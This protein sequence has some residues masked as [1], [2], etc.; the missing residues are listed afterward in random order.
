MNFCLGLNVELHRGYYNHL[1]KMFTSMRRK[2]T[3]KNH[4]STTSIYGV[5]GPC[6]FTYELFELCANVLLN[7]TECREQ[8]PK[9]TA[10]FSELWAPVLRMIILSGPLI[11]T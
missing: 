8:E 3:Y 5:R 10:L 7:E 1:A 11:C 4:I 2:F 6:C 9:T